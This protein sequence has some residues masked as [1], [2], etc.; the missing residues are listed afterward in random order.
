M[1]CLGL[2]SCAFQPRQADSETPPIILKEGWQL[3]WGDSPVDAEGNPVWTH[4]DLENPGWE[5]VSSVLHR[6]PPDNQHYHWLRIR[7]PQADWPEPVLY[8]PSVFLHVQ[9]FLEDQPLYCYGSF[10]RAYS[11]RFAPFVPHKVLLPPDCYGKILYL[12]MFS[13]TPNINGIEGRVSL[14][15][16]ESLLPR[17]IK[18]D[19]GTFLVSVFCIIVGLFA[20]ATCLDPSAKRPYAALSFGFFSIFIGLAFITR[21]SPLLWL[22]PAPAL[23][24]FTLFISFFLFPAAIVAFVDAVIGPGYKFYLR[25]LWQAH[26]VMLVPA[27]VLDVTGVI[28]I[29]QLSGFLRFLW[30][31]DTVSVLVAAVF[32][33]AKGKFEARIMLL[34][35]G[36][37]SALALHDMFGAPTGIWLMPAGAFIFIITLGVILFHR[38]TENSR[39]LQLYSREIEE[40]S[41]KLEEAKEELEDYSRTLESKVEERTRQVKEKHAQLVQSSKMASLGSLVAGVAHE[42]NT[43]IG[44]ISSMHNTLMR[45][46][47][48]LKVQLGGSLSEVEDEQLRIKRSLQAVDEANRVISTGTE[49]VIEIVRRLRSFARL[50]EAEL[51]DADINEGLEDTLTMIHHEI[52]HNIVIHK[53]FGVLPLISCYPGRLNQVFLNLLIN[54]RQAI[55][56]EGEIFITTRRQDQTISIKIRDTGTGIS[57]ENLERIFD[58]GFTTKGVGVG[59]GLG[60]SICYQ[61]IQDHRGEIKVDSELGKGTT[62]TVILPMDLEKRLEKIEPAA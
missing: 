42:I 11:N 40:K 50:D 35:L 33:A 7:L 26:L 38:F 22:V 19:M 17:L 56:G 55:K 44:A 23:W 1:I 12:R 59:T 28:Y 30:A 39:H 52:K 51:K 18:Q 2:A 3:R 10:Q 46:V 48:K 29:P 4:Q 43:P 47:D 57:P 13:D 15:A 41:R 24:Y 49:R 32:A 34:G 61:I 14:G 20:L 58:P 62:F 21:V 5:S 60:L 36:S 54:A 9:V 45:A 8:L 53:D 27:L 25:R 31:L 37:F 6:R 16:R